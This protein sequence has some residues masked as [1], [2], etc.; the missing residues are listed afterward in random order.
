[1][2][3]SRML[4]QQQ[5]VNLVAPR[6]V[7]SQFSNQELNLCPLH[8][9]ADSL[10]LSHQGKPHM[11]FACLHAKLLQS[12]PTLCNSRVCSPS[13]SCVHGMPQAKTLEWVAVSSSRG[14]SQTWDRT[15]VSLLQLQQQADSL[16]LSQR[17]SPMCCL[18]N[19]K[20]DENSLQK[21]G[22]QT[23]LESEKLLFT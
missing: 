9:Q 1:M 17:G 15:L 10:P 19:I 16:L 21:Q 13:G 22:F 4:Q 12:C 3:S 5:H 8:W 23:C 14:S 6:H 7:G 11:L 18:R 2:N 20:N